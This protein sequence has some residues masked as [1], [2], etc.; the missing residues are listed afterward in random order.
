M[1]DWTK[2][3]ARAITIC[4]AWATRLQAELPCS[5]YLFGSAI[6]QGGEQFDAETS[7]LDL[8]IVLPDA[9]SP[10]KRANLLKQLK[11]HKLALELLIIRPLHRSDCVEP[12][13]SIVV[14]TPLELAA[15]VHKSG[16]RRF[17][18]KN[19]FL[20][21]SNGQQSLGLPGAGVSSIGDDARQAVEYVQMTRNKFLA[22]GANGTG[23]IKRYDAAEPLPKVLTRSAAQLQADAPPGGWY[24]TRYGLEFFIEEL[25]RIRYDSD[26][27]RKLQ[28]KVS[29]RCGAR[30]KRKALSAFNQLLLSEVLFDH[31][32]AAPLEP[33]GAWEIRFSGVKPEPHERR[34]LVKR[35]HK[36][37]PDA[38]ILGVYE[39]SIIVRLL[40]SQSS[41][42]LV[43]ELPAATLR[44]WFAVEEV[45]VSEFGPNE[46]FEG[47]ATNSVFDRLATRIGDWRPPSGESRARDEASLAQWLRSWITGSGLRVTGIESEPRIEENG[48]TLRPD[49]AL[50]FDEQGEPRT[51]VIELVRFRSRTQ[52]YQQ[53]ER[54]RGL[55]IRAF[56]VLT[57]TS[58]ELAALNADLAR[59]SATEEHLRVIAVAVN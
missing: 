26:E 22:V 1:D 14:I 49:L 39:G 44:R 15:N 32:A 53:V 48:R 43:Q 5:A 37:V 41:Y 4:R 50:R 34:R 16:A 51:L 47:F 20:D 45:D 35:L 6:Y 11:T 46:M 10:T 24:D 27:L 31:A 52:L 57:G 23:G 40:S 3:A 12:G 2:E 9:L 54:L 29:V 13:V 56:I 19:F 33:K 21:L 55:S 7:D 17:F 38:E 36:L 30:G 25:R 18:D 28:K 8:V 58:K 42:S 59:I